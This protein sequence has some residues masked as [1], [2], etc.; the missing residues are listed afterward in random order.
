MIKTV[1]F[2]LWNTIFANR[3]Y[4][5]IR[6]HY[7]NHFLKKNEIVLSFNKVKDAFNSTFHISDLNLEKINYRHIYTHERISNLFQ[8]LD[9]K[10]SESQIKEIEKDFEEVMLNAPPP[11][12]TGVKET[13]KELSPDFNIGLIS[14]TGITPGRIIK[15]V[16]DI[17]DIQKYFQL[18]LFSDETGVYKPNPLMFETALKKLKCKPQNA[19]HIGDI[20]E[21]D[22][23]GAKNCN[24]LTIWI[25][26]SSS[27]RSQNIEP[28]YEIQKI[29]DAVEIIKRI[30]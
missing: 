18:T 8:V 16:F 20:L 24:M 14:N 25:N 4:S 7:L 3:F 5:D 10:Y 13:L 17:Y 27:S 1:T 2:D 22:I 29:Y 23:K 21:T 11:L 19:I 30:K 28:D 26:D 12:K 6:L 9:I 15:K